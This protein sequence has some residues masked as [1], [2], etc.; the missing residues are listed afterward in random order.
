MFK[1]K[2]ALLIA[3]STILLCL[4]LIVG[5][6]YALFTDSAKVTNH[7]RAG[8]MDVTLIRTNYTHKVLDLQT[9]YLTDRVATGDELNVDFSGVTNEN[10]FGL[11]MED[12]AATAYDD[13]DLM[14]PGVSYR[15][16]MKL[17]NNGTVAFNYTINIVYNETDANG[18]ESDSKF[19]EQLYVTLWAPQMNEDG[20]VKVDGNGNTVW[21]EEAIAG[22]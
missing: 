13:R 7:L 12:D 14:V 18:N 15:S 5:G 20:T 3:C 19:A 11:T 1:R 16:E 10:L 22:A 9:G 4:A 2:R 21:E 8:F 17:T 6:T